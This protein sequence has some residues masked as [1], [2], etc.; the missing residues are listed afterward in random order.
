MKLLERLGERQLP[1]VISVVDIIAKLRLISSAQRMPEYQLK[2]GC[3]GIRIPSLRI[4]AHIRV[5]Q[6][7]RRQAALSSP[8]SSAAAAA[9]AAS[10]S[11]ANRLPN[12]YPTILLYKRII[13]DL[14]SASPNRRSLWDQSGRSRWLDAFVEQRPGSGLWSCWVFIDFARH[15]SCFKDLINFGRK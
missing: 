13:G 8:A 5:T 7:E 1:I 12:N 3:V 14:S 2:A 10:V 9:A 6:R 4:S 15:Y 11:S